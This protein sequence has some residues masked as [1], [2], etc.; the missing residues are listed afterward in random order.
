MNVLNKK[1]WLCAL[2]KFKLLRQ[3]KGDFVNCCDFFKVRNFC[4]GWP[5]SFLALG[6]KNLATPLLSISLYLSE[7]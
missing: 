4:Q 1:I 2:N 5:L 3:I 6:I 7:R